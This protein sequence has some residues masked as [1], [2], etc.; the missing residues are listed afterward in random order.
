MSLSANTTLRQGKH[1]WK[2]EKTMLEKKN[3]WCEESVTQLGKNTDVANAS[4]L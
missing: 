4:S 3:L 2:I 1:C